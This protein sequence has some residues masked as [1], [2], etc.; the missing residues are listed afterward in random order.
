M[1]IFTV[2]DDCNLRDF[3]DFNYPQG[4]F[5][6]SRLLRERNVKVN[7]A[8]VGKN[9]ELKRGDVVIFYT[10]PIQEAKPSHYIAYEDENI[11]IADKFDGVTSEGLLSE[12]RG[13]AAY[14][15]HRLDRNTRGLIV[16]AKT[17][18]AQREL[19]AAFRERRVGKEYLAL[20]KDNFKSDKAVLTAYLR[21]NAD[22]A[23]VRIYNKSAPDCQKIVTEYEILKRR[24]NLALVK[25][26]LHTGK[27]HQIRAH[28]A[29]IGCPVVGDNKYGDEALNG[30]LGLS[31]QQ[32]IAERLSFSLKGNLEYL[33]G[34]TFKSSFKI[35]F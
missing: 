30:V 28:L 12:I 23:F 34:K 27:T 5:A 26:K 33:N 6:L 9:V 18:G 16:F 3:T 19:V 35:D 2:T 14:A 15:V 7:G 4:A 31:R 13:K 24:D 10:T 11:L 21:K 8:R 29:H 20:C 25:I 1:K 17:P 22:S 32:L